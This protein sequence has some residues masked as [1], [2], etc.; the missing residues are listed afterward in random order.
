MQVAKNGFC[1][2]TKHKIFTTSHPQ[3]DYF[4]APWK[5]HRTQNDKSTQKYTNY[6]PGGPIW[7]VKYIFL[8]L[9]SVLRSFS[10]MLV[11][12][13]NNNVHVK[14]TCFFVLTQ[15]NIQAILIDGRYTLPKF[16][17]ISQM[18]S[19]DKSFSELSQNVLPWLYLLLSIWYRFSI[20]LT[21]RIDLDGVKSI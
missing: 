9:C 13:H 15:L 12:K 19:I 16:Q 21:I 8:S 2:K 10:L 14:H 3:Q 11:T 1:I 20:N 18:L 7:Q 17:L 5:V 4:I 6:F